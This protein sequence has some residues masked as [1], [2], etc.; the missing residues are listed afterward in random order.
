[1]PRVAVIEIGQS[2][3]PDLVEELAAVLPDDTELLE[4]GALDGVDPATI[5]PIWFDAENPLSTRLADGQLILVDE[6]WI[7]PHVQAAIDR[8]EAAEPDVLV[9]LCAGA[10]PGLTTQRP[11][12]RPADVLAA[13]LRARGTSTVLVVVPSPRQIPASEAKWRALG[14]DPLMLGTPLPKG[15]DDVVEAASEV[16]AVVLDY[17]GHPA[18]LIDR[19]EDALESE[20]D[21]LLYDLGRYAA[22]ATAEALAARDAASSQSLA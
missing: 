5:P 3:R 1:M 16:K 13:V 6:P 19:L 7:A 10:F 20:T 8:A 22:F 14:L 9:L 11:L 21:A 17:V 15:L 2:P 18:K 12:I 4:S